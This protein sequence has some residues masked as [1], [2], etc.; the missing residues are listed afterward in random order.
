M[1]NDFQPGDVL[2]SEPELSLQFNVSRPVVRETL[3]TLRAKALIESRTKKGV[4]VRP[5]TDWN[6]LDPEVIGWFYEVGP[7]RS[8]LD[9]LCEVRQ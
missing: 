4:R 1:R 3:N 2:S 9:S 7:D 5:R 6:V 8:F